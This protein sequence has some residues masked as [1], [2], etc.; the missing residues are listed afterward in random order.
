MYK[1]VRTRAGVWLVPPKLNEKSQP[2]VDCLCNG[3]N[4]YDHYCRDTMK[5]SRQVITLNTTQALI[6]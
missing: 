3:F 4:I 1:L 5:T 2:M 6:P